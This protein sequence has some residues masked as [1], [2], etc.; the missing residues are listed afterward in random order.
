MKKSWIVSSS[1]LLLVF[2]WASIAAA[3]DENKWQYEFTIYG[4]YAGIDGT[5]NVPGVPGPGVNSTVDASDILDSLEMVF[6]GG[7]AAQ[8]NKW[9]IITDLVYMDVGGY[10]N[11]TLTT[12]SGQPVNA[13]LDLDISSWLVNG[14]IGYDV[15]QAERGTLAVVGGVRYMAL[16]V[17]TKVGLLGRQPE[18]S[19]SEGLL[20]G[21][22]GVRGFIRLNENWY[23]PYYADI[24]TGGSE[25]SWQLFA[26]VGYR[27]SWGDIRLGYRYLGYDMDD[28]KVL[29]DLALSGPVLG[30]GF[31]F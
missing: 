22:V 10:K 4:W 3:Q 6:M 14:A 24:G 12:G 1:L 21:I 9:S 17:D 30:V 7:F 2:C 29:Q 11:T 26:G 13:A 5:V 8:K 18:R 19:G 27:F 20:D 15:V 28:D 23:V 31:R 25:L 16:D